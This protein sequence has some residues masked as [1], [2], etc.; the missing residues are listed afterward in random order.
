MHGVFCM[1][2]SLPAPTIAERRRFARFVDVGCVAC[3]Q[4]EPPRYSVPEVHHLLSGGIRRGH[5]YTVPL[6]PWHHRGVGGPVDAQLAI[7]GPSLALTP[8]NFRLHFGSDADLLHMTNAIVGKIDELVRA[9]LPHQ[10]AT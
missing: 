8:D 2:S 7:R 5:S 9:H 10:V 4:L 1:K 6:C 3:L